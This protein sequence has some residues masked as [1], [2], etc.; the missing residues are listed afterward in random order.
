MPAIKQTTNYTGYPMQAIDCEFDIDGFRLRGK[1]WGRRDGLPVLALHGW[2]D[3]CASFDFLAPLLPQ[4]DLLCLD[5]AGQGLSDHRNH[6]GAYNI[7]QDV[8]EVFALADQLGWQEFGLLG[9]SRG[10]AIAMLA[11]GTFPER[12]SHLAMLDGICPQVDPPENAPLTLAK[13][14]VS[15]NQQVPRAKRYYSS[16]EDAVKARENGMLALS[17][18]D[19]RILAERGVGLNSEGYSWLYDSKLLA[20]SELRLSLPQVEAFVA[21]IQA[22]MLLILAENSF[23]QDLQELQ[24]WL[25]RHSEIPQ[26]RVPGD[27]HCHMSGQAQRIARELNHFLA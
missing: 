4:L 19:A 12:V 6:R 9:H 22:P 20:G 14:I 5:L 8:G 18:T 2:L 27:H 23:M 17:H 21:R 24:T 10:A 11:A 3:N 7:W 1:R 25:R 15:L 16:F 26:I 13:S